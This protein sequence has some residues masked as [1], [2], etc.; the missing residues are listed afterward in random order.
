VAPRSAL[1]HLPSFHTR[2][3]PDRPSARWARKGPGPKPPTAQGRSVLPRMLHSPRRRPT[4]E[5][6]RGRP[7]SGSAPSRKASHRDRCNAS[8]DFR[9]PGTARRL[10]AVRTNLHLRQR[11]RWVVTHTARPQHR[12]HLRDCSPSIQTDQGRSR[13]HEGP[14]S[15]S[16][17]GEHE[18]RYARMR[19]ERA[20]CPLVVRGQG[21]RRE[22]ASSARSRS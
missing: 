4:R 1:W 22:R 9:L 2:P 14:P 15:I 10:R 16:G 19:C 8:P 12:H 6:P 21:S 7:W 13:H 18:P 3:C 17:R 20:R 11:R 5:P